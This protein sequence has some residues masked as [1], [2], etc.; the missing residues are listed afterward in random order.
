MECDCD[1][2]VTSLSFRISIV[3]VVLVQKDGVRSQLTLDAGCDG[4]GV[5]PV[6]GP[7]VGPDVGPAVPVGEGADAVG[8]ALGGSVS[9]G[10]VVAGA[11]EVAEGVGV[12]RARSLSSSHNSTV[13]AVPMIPAATIAAKTCTNAR[14]IKR[15]L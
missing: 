8:D 1:P 10:P 3:P 11:R 6:E 13:R 4:G 5:D 15:L 7:D 2:D 9:A 14:R 12:P